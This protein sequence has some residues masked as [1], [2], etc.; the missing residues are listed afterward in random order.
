MRT[1]P[2]TVVALVAAILS[3]ALAIFASCRGGIPPTQARTERQAVDD[4]ERS[5]RIDRQLADMLRNRIAR[6]EETHFDLAQFVSVL[7]SIGSAIF[8]TQIIRGARK[9]VPAPVARMIREIQP[10][11]VETWIA[12]ARRLQERR[13]HQA[14]AFVPPPDPPILDRST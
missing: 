9:P 6:A 5:G 1:P 10:D 3:V 11:D 14:G 7:I 13:T 12:F 2:R 8:G 4:L